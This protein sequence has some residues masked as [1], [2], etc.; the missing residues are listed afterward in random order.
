MCK[1]LGLVLT[2]FFPP[3]DLACEQ[4]FFFFFF[5]SFQGEHLP[6]VAEVF[7]HVWREKKDKNGE[8]GHYEDLTETT[9]KPDRRLL[10]KRHYSED[11][12]AVTKPA[13]DFDLFHA[14]KKGQKKRN[15]TI[16]IKSSKSY[17]VI[18]GLKVWSVFGT[19]NYN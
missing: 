7:S 12:K 16:R 1:K 19:S 3:Q 8:A 15:I 9:P 11:N 14:K 10:H 13:K 4:T 17:P 18:L 2:R 6:W 5:F